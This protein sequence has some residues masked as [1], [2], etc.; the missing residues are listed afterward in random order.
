MLKALREPAIS[1]LWVGQVM[2][3]IGDDIYRVALTWMAVSLVGAD[4]GFLA[5]GQ[6]AIV[7][8]LTLVGGRWSDR[9]CPLRTMVAVD[10]LRM[11]AVLVPVALYALGAP[12]MTVLWVVALVVAGLSAFFDPAMQVTLPSLAPNAEVLQGTVGLMGTTFRLARTVGPCVVGLLSGLL[13]MIHFFTID[14]MTFLLSAASVLAVRDLPRRK[15]I[16]RAIPASET[17]RDTLLAGVRVVRRCPL[18]LYLIFVKTVTGG[19]WNLVYTLG[20]ALLVT[21]IAPNDLRA[22]GLVMAAYGVGNLVSALV[23][24]NMRRHRPAL[25]LFLGYVWMGVGFVWVAMA[26]S[27][28]TLMAAA[29]FSALGGPMNDMTFLDLIQARY[30]LE[31]I[32]RVFRLR[33]SVEMAATLLGMLAA[34]GLMRLFD[35]RAVIAACGVA[36]FVVSAV[37]WVVFRARVHS[38][39]GSLPLRSAG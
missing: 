29:A 1:R 16:T 19:T 4:T 7:L 27:I 38:A 2:S 33:I 37:G 15:S 20:L 28:S 39:D 35:V 14:A 32:P 31:E 26:P 8:A 12:S 22:Y 17:M 13:P 34:P 11:V 36:T 10:L 9:W 25:I 3:T 6:A 30:S 21:Q 23:V 24:G 5:A 18:M